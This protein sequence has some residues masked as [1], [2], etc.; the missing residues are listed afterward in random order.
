MNAEF[1]ERYQQ[2]KIAS[3]KYSKSYEELD[4]NELADVKRV[5]ERK[6]KLEELVLS[7]P[8]AS[9]ISIPETQIEDAIEEISSRFEDSEEFEHYLSDNAIVYDDLVELIS[10]ELHVNSVLEYVSADCDVPTAEDISLFY[11]MN[12][13]K[14]NHPEIRTAR[15]ILIT[16]NEDSP[17]NSRE[18]SLK[19]INQISSRLKKKPKLFEQQAL[20]HSECP[21]SLQGGLLGK[22][23]KGVLYPELE[24]VLFDMKPNQL[25]DVVESELGF[26]ILRCDDVLSEGVLGLEEVMP[27]LKEHL[28]DRNR[29]QKQRQWLDSLRINSGVST[30]D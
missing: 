26:H 11:Y 20:K 5:S 22:V 14:F 17:E 13:A 28:L 29:Q 25:S 3:E 4:A 1:G 2:I 10:R 15:H 12:I 30:R 9:R 6:I 21:T 19:R 7:S 18:N 24:K 27:K 8:E 23:K 16:V